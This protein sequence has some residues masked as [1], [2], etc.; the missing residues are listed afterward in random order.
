MVFRIAVCQHDKPG[1]NSAFDAGV[2]LRGRVMQMVRNKA[3]QVSRKF[4]LPAVDNAYEIIGLG[5]VQRLYW[6]RW[7]SITGM[8]VC[9]PRVFY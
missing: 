7:P 4:R 2:A 1:D 8:P 9:M 5:K 6:Q 3:V